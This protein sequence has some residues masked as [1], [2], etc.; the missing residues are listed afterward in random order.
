MIL[1]LSHGFINISIGSSHNEDKCL[2]IQMFEENIDF[3]NL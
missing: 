1:F 3:K 2:D